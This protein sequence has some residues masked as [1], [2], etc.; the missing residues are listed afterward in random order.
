MY[1][2]WKVFGIGLLSLM[3]IWPSRIYG[4]SPQT[5]IEDGKIIGAL[6]RV[7]GCVMDQFADF[8]RLTAPAGDE[9]WIQTREEFKPPFT[10][11][12]QARTDGTNIRQY[13]GLGLIIL[14]WEVDLDELR[15]VHP[16]TGDHMGFDGVGRIEP[17]VWHDIVWEFTTDRMRI[18]VDGEE[19]VELKG[20]Y[21]PLDGGVG[22]GPAWGSK[23]DIRSYIVEQY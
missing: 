21:T 3:L 6:I 22:F 1:S 14:N 20:D 4:A 19:R 9:Y 12:L 18:I 17:D 2:T 11:R 13:F 15:I 23:I 5:Y 16:A 7:R 8:V 10:V